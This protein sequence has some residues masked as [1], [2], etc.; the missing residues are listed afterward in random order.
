MYG[1][2]SMENLQ[3]TR[4]AGCDRNRQHHA[5]QWWVGHRMQ[6]V[7]ERGTTVVMVLLAVNP[8]QLQRIYHKKRANSSEGFLVSMVRKAAYMYGRSSS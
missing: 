7:K 8:R 3:K 4:A 6:S 2:S 5:M 1:E